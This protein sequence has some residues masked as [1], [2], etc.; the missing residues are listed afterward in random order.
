VANAVP[1]VD[2]QKYGLAGQHRR[3]LRLKLIG[4]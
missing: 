1:Q 4:R 3:G 2:I